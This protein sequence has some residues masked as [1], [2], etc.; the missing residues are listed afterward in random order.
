MVLTEQTLADGRKY[1]PIPKVCQV[2]E[3]NNPIAAS[4][5]GS[6]FRIIVC[7]DHA[8]N[9]G[10]HTTTLGSG[11]TC[12]AQNCGRPSAYILQHLSDI[13]SPWSVGNKITRCQA[14]F[15]K[16]VVDLT[17]PA[18]IVVDGV[19]YVRKP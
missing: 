18:E 3:C 1:I 12:G 14:C 8:S 11:K 9:N 5:D 7:D 16:M 13:G 19:T 4:V 6:C 15:D 17:K 10:L 2:K